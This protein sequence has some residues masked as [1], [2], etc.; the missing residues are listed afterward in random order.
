MRTAHCHC[1]LTCSQTERGLSS[2]SV[3]LGGTFLYLSTLHN[4]YADNLD[5][6]L[7][8]LIES[9][10]MLVINDKGGK[11]IKLVVFLEGM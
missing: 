11:T 1:S 2:P 9:G 5:K 3:S 7:G 4:D 8:E 6:C 10:Q